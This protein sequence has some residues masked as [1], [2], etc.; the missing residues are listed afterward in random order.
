MAIPAWLIPAGISAITSFMGAVKEPP[1]AT[2]SVGDI[3]RI[4]GAYRQQGLAGIASLAREERGRATQRLAASGLN[5]SLNLQQALYNPILERLSGARADLE[6]NL[7]QAYSG[8]IGQRAGQEFQ[9]DVMGY[10]NI[11]NFL[12]GLSDLA[13]QGALGLGMSGAQFDIT[14]L[15]PFL[16][17]NKGQPYYNS[18]YT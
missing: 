3:N 2:L 10:E 14:K 9:G 12:A 11:I 1:G 4:I 18:P 17:G 6:G 13:G 8:L 15:F 16:G 7:A 5:P